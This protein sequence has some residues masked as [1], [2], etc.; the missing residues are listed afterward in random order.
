MKGSKHMSKELIYTP[1]GI[2]NYT[3]LS[4]PDTK[5]NPDGVYS[6]TLAFDKKT[7]GVKEMCK[8]LMDEY[9]KA[10]KPKKKAGKKPYEENDEGKIEVRFNQKAI[11]RTKDGEEFKKTV[12]LLDSKGKPVKAD[13]GNGS[14]LKACFSIRP[15][16]FNGCGI[17]IDLNAVQIVDL[18]EYTGSNFEFEE[19]AGGFEGTDEEEPEV[20][21]ENWDNDEDDDPPEEE[22]SGAE[23]GEDEPF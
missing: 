2:S 7:K 16:D 23:D 8:K 11:I 20:N 22:D 3:W 1:K 18:V 10:Q 4:R 9:K 19:E 6:V 12:A 13:V 17:S 5:F 15:Y 14:T 21:T